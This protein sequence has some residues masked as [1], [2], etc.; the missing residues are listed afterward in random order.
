MYKAYLS[1]QLFGGY[2]SAHGGVRRQLTRLSSLLL[3]VGPKDDT[4]SSDLVVS[5]SAC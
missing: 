5:A 2:H 1:L 3:H 4:P